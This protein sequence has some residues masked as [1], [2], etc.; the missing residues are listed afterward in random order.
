MLSLANAV[1]T[2]AGSE[3]VLTSTNQINSLVFSELF[4]KLPAH[5]PTT[6]NTLT[7]LST[8]EGIRCQTIINS[9]EKLLPP[10]VSL[11]HIKGYQLAKV[12]THTQCGVILTDNYYILG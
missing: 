1:L 4:N 5:Q 3:K 2:E 8:N 7:L 10:E 6:T 11:T 12:I 9:L